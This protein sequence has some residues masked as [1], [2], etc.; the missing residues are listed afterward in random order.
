MIRINIICEGQTEE[1]FVKEILA[2]HLAP[3]GIGATPHNLGTGTNYDKLRKK[4]VKWLK[5]EP[6]SWVTT[7]I[8]LY[9]MPDDFPGWEE[10]RNKPPQDKVLALE[11][12]LKSNIE[13]EKLDNWRFIPHYQLHEFEALLFSEPSVMETWLGIDNPLKPGAFSAIRKAFNTPEDINDKRET[14][15]SKRISGLVKNYQKPTMGMIIASEIGLE[16]MR[17]ECP[18][19]NSWLTTLEMLS[20]MKA[21]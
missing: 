16:R 15:P 21:E 6:K 13:S 1:N 5:E 10:H 11:A 17:A 8:D 20:E 14:A 4:I 2:P 12:A 3:K 19:F 18:H 9:A 7:L